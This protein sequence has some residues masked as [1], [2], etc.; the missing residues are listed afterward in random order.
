MF[1]SKKS[2]A[3]QGQYDTAVSIAKVMTKIDR[4]WTS[5]KYLF[6][7]RVPLSADVKPT[8]VVSMV[9]IGFQGIFAF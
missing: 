3:Y 9:G 8:C 5:Q 7:N 4:F 2:D 1:L 6:H